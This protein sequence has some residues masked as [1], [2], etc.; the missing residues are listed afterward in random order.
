[1]PYLGAE[2]RDIHML[3]AVTRNIAGNKEWQGLEMA[4]HR[5]SPALRAQS[6]GKE[7][8]KWGGELAFQF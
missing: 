5:A 8:K 3:A 2:N 1:M 4:A 7:K 6:T